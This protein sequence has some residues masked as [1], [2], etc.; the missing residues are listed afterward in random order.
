[1]KLPPSGFP[2]TSVT[3]LKTFEAL[4][5]LYIFMSFHGTPSVYDRF[6]AGL[7]NSS[8]ILFKTSNEMEKLYVDYIKSQFNNK[9]VLLAGPVVPEPRS[10]E[11]DQRYVI[12]LGFH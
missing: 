11:L 6:L 7:K 4:D 8:A 10:G 2:K 1:M 5:L 12:R 9:P 3:S